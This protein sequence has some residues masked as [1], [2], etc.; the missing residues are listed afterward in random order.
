MQARPHPNATSRHAGPDCWRWAD[1][2]IAHAVVLSQLVKAAA[3]AT[4]QH[5]GRVMRPASRRTGIQ[6]MQTRPGIAGPGI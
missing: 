2:L 1:M 4:G 5:V 6:P 3:Q